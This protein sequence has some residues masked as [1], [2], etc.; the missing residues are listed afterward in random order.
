[1]KLAE[2]YPAVAVERNKIEIRW[3]RDGSGKFGWRNYA[4][5]EAERNKTW[6]LAEAWRKAQVKYFAGHEEWF[7]E[8]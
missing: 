7:D 3:K 5:V 1:M 6:K 2:S 8:M 4:A